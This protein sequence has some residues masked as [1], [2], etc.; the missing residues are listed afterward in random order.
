MSMQSQEDQMN[1]WTRVAVKVPADGDLVDVRLLSGNV[2]KSVEYSA[3]RFWKVRTANGG[4]TYEVEAWRE[5]AKQPRS[6]TAD[7]TTESTD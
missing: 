4:H 7:G 2:V 6:K 3:G 5:I 1:E